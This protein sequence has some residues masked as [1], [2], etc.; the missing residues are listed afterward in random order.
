MNVLLYFFGGEIMNIFNF[1]LIIIGILN[2]FVGVKWSTDGLCELI[3]KT[4][5]LAS[6]GYLIFYALYLEGILI[7]INR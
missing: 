4:L 3:F 1:I 7:V 2:L 6:A 5:Y